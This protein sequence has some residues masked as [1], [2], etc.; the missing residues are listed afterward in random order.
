M[1][2]LH[3]HQ[4][5]TRDN[6]TAVVNACIIMDISVYSYRK[7]TKLYMKITL[8]TL[9]STPPPQ[10]KKKDAYIEPSLNTDAESV[11]CSNVSLASFL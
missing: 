11:K 3:E 9:Y 6:M 10:T 5:L 4:I 1:V 2:T 8:L 7:V